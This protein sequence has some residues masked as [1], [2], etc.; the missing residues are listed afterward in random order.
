MQENPLVSIIV[1]TYNSSKYVLETLES[2]KSQTYQNIELI[3]S[4][5][6]STDSTVEICKNWI[7]DNKTRFIRTDLITAT[8]NNGIPAN[9]NRGIE[10]AQGDWIKLVAGDD[11]LFEN[12]IQDNINFAFNNDGAKI[13]HSIR[14][15]FKI[16]DKYKKIIQ[17][18]KIDSIFNEKV[19][20]SEDQYQLSL[21]EIGCPPNTLFINRDLLTANK[22]NENF[23]LSED[24]VFLLKNLKNGNK[25]QFLNKETY[26]YRVHL[27][28]VYHKNKTEHI[29]TSWYFSSRIPV[30]RK[31]VFKDTSSIEKFGHYY[32]HLIAH[33][34][35]FFFLNKR[36]LFTRILNKVISFPASYIFN[37][38]R[39]KIIKKIAKK[40]D[41]KN[42]L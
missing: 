41:L 5:D 39:K 30:L 40:Y 16:E 33:L 12:C 34:F 13:I 17:K 21:R 27:E 6:C 25:F 31:Y 14:V 9:C 10:S 35:K 32:Q 29:Y 15:T 24:K 26:W 38:S 4:D 11:L 3:I 18:T 23:P 28:S 1:I 22:Y 36:N 8:K 37:K 42:Y 20:T 19:L 7:D 2:A